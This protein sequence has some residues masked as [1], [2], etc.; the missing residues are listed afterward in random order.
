MKFYYSLPALIALG[1]AE[2]FNQTCL[3]AICSAVADSEALIAA[4]QATGEYIIYSEQKDPMLCTPEMS[5]RSRAIELWATM[6]Y[7]GKNGIDEMV[8]GFYHRAKQLEK[9]LR[10]NGF[11]IINEVVFNQV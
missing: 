9:G 1:F 5:K 4:L 6:K 10:E 2:V 11:R 3:S 7:L 8:T